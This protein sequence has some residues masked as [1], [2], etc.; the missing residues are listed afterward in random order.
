MC[1]IWAI[2]GAEYDS[3][4]HEL[5]FMKIVSRGPDFTT[6]EQTAPQLWFGFH[7]LAIVQVI[8][9]KLYTIFFKF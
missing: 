9:N 5:E 3:T 8:L 7:R 1:G 2:L 4:N 6:V